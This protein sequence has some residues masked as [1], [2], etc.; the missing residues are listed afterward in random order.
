MDIGHLKVKWIQFLQ[1]D[2]MK[3]DLEIVLDRDEQSE[4]IV[5]FWKFSQGTKMKDIE[6]IREH[7]HLYI[8][9]YLYI[10]I[11]FVFIFLS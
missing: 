1:G 4:W 5:T 6:E 7:I 3:T 8:N 10:Y 9:L 2:W 11:S